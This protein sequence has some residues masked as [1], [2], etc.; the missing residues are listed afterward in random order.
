MKLRPRWNAAARENSSGGS[1]EA[2]SIASWSDA[3]P[4]SEVMMQGRDAAE[5]GALSHLAQ[6]LRPCFQQFPGRVD[7][8][9]DQP[10]SGA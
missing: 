2:C 9:R 10:L 4:I 1:R 5:A 3:D 7:P 8:R 6:A